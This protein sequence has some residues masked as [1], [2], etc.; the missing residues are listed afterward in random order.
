M[1]LWTDQMIPRIPG[2]VSC[3]CLEPG[4]FVGDPTPLACDNML[5][6][7]FRYLYRNSEWSNPGR[8]CK[9]HLIGRNRPGSCPTFTHLIFWLA[10][11]VRENITSTN[12][13]EPPFSEH[14]WDQALL[15]AQMG[16]CSFAGVVACRLK[17][18][19]RR[20]GGGYS[21]TYGCL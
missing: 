16:F 20:G 18:S 10:I 11:G 6:L 7:V 13:V 19:S 17:C 9:L 14:P 15:F 12:T 1:N 5:L 8:W 4:W 2:P 3:R 21:K